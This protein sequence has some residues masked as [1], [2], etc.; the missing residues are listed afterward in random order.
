MMAMSR[1]VLRLSFIGFFETFV[2]YCFDVV[3]L[4]GCIGSSNIKYGEL[5]RTNAPS[6]KAPPTIYVTVLHTGPSMT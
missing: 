2:L 1:W 6:G 5:Y 3:H 4:Q